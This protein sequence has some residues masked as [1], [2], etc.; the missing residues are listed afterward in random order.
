M[1]EKFLPIAIRDTKINE[2][3]WVIVYNTPDLFPTLE[4]WALSILPLR[5][6]VLDLGMEWSV[7][8]IRLFE[9]FYDQ[10]KQPLIPI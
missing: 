10:S 7:S 1:P 9:T 8:Y 6:F 3:S 4:I 2:K 5:C